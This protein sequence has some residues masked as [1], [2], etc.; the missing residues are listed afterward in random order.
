MKVGKL[1]SL[2]ELD[3]F[4]C[5]ELQCLPDSIVDLSNLQIFRLSGCHKLENLP[6]ELGKLQSLVEL[7]LFECSKLRC[8]PDSIVDLPNMQTSPFS[9][10]HKL[11]NLLTT[12]ETSKLGGT[13]FI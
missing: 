4:E 6:A 1:Q 12:G 11:E 9:G 8:V 13:E 7:D 5:S 3:L 10:F 2:V